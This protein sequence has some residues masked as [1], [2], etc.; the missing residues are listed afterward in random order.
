MTGQSVIAS[1]GNMV[2]NFARS[3]LGRRV[4]VAAFCLTIAGC[5]TP[6]PL[7]HAEMVNEDSHLHEVQPGATSRFY[8]SAAGE[9]RKLDVKCTL[10]G[11]V[12]PV[13]LVFGGVEP[14]KWARA[15]ASFSIGEQELNIDIEGAVIPDATGYPFFDFVN[16]DPDRLLWHQC[17]NN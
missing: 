12:G 3:P 5:A 14:E 9:R 2:R 1:R 8:I 15:H 7:L 6:P 17:Y 11:P 16:D 10:S 13:R 4:L